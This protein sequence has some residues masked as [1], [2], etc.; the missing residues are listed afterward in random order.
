M[1]SPNPPPGWPLAN[2]EGRRALPSQRF[3]G[4]AERAAGSDNDSSVSSGRGGYLN[5]SNA[6]S[7][8]LCLRAELLAGLQLHERGGAVNVS[9]K[10]WLDRWPAFRPRSTEAGVAKADVQHG[11]R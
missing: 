2:P 3:R 8:A 4:V 6:G 1:Q 5:D 11:A 9:V 10:E 7:D